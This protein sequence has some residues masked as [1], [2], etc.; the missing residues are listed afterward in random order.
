MKYFIIAMFVLWIVPAVML[1]FRDLINEK[2]I[3]NN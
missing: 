3:D 2:N 1:A